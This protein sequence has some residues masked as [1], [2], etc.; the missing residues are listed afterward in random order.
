MQVATTVQANVPCYLWCRAVLLSMTT[1][2][3]AAQLR[4]YVRWSWA[5]E[6]CQLSFSEHVDVLCCGWGSQELRQ[7]SDSVIINFN[8]GYTS[9]I[10]GFGGASCQQ[11]RRTG[12]R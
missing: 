7:R 11:V 12:H 2:F 5:V 8:S 6:V 10:A 9:E 1:N 4:S 3:D